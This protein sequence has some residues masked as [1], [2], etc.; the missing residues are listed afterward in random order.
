MST[1]YIK[2]NWQDGDIITADKMNNIENGI[3]G[4]EEATTHVKEDF[5]I[6]NDAVGVNRV[7]GSAE[8]QRYKYTII[9]PSFPLSEGITYKVTFSISEA[10]SNSVYCY[11]IDNTDPEDKNLYPGGTAL[12]S[13]TTSYTV[14]FTPTKDYADV[15]ASVYTSDVL[16]ASVVIETI[17]ANKIDALEERTAN[18]KPF[19]FGH[20]GIKTSV[21]MGYNLWSQGCARVRDTLVGFNPSNDDH[22]NT[23]IYTSMYYADGYAYN[24]RGN[25]NLGHCASADYRS[26]TDVM[27]V[28][29]GTYVEGVVPT[30]YLISNAYSTTD[31]G[32]DI[33]VTDS[34]VMAL[35]FT[36]LDGTGC[37]ACF[38][39]T[40]DIIYVMTADDPAH[41]FANGNRYIYKMLLGK[42]SVNMAT[43]HPSDSVGTFVSGKSDTEFNGTAY[44]MNRYVAQYPVELQGLKYLNGRLLLSMDAQVDSIST[45][46]LA[47]IKMYD[48]DHS[49]V[50]ED[51]LWIPSLDTDGNY[52]NSEP[53]GFAIADGIGYIVIFRNS[54]SENRS[55]T[56][57][58]YLNE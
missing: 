25:H 15:R 51:A 29:N 48:S 1:E 36:T 58:F 28:A 8:T 34:N 31:S 9:L 55:K 14:Q 54:M 39:E 42:G 20:N 24:A 35:E 49:F 13:G 22:S 12:V 43:L 40:S 52:V 6:L 30:V 50:I 10:I 5:D 4:I 7:S 33:L 19:E 26:D 37:V 21:F 45:G 2:T 53:E 17:P 57:A 46:Y 41:P 32:N 27:L 11:I 38:G 23:S 18:L 3:K 47:Y 56:L 44:I 16:T